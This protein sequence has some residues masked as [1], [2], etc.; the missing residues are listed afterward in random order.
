MTVSDALLKLDKLNYLF[1]FIQNQ[2]KKIVLI[3]KCILFWLFRV[4]MTLQKSFEKWIHI[5]KKIISVKNIM[6]SHDCTMSDVYI[7][8]E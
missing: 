8:F 2:H 1:K 4:I 3:I 6:V 5:N 7:Y